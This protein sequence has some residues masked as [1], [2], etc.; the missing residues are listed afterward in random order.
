LIE[1]DNVVL[2]RSVTPSASQDD[3]NSSTSSFK[4][5]PMPDFSRT[6]VPKHDH[7][8]LTQPEGF[9]LRSDAR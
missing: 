6:F 1:S 7:S 3:L 9:K 8:T 4:A 2:T 5:K